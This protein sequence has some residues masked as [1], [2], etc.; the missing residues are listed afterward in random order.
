VNRLVLAELRKIFSTK[1]WWG[2][3][4]PVGCVAAVVGFAGAWF[5]DLALAA[6]DFEGERLPTLALTVPYCMQQTTVFAVV[7]GLIGGAGEFRHKTI[8]TTYLTAPSRGH[9]LAAKLI[10]YGALGVL[11]GAA[12]AVV[13]SLA[14]LVRSGGDAFPSPA[15]WLAITALGCVTTLAWTVLGVGLGTLIS[16]QVAVLIS[17]LVYKLLLEGVASII[18]QIEQVGL[19]EVARL[20]PGAASAALATDY[21]IGA[22]LRVAG[23]DGE[24]VR[25]ALEGLVGS[26]GQLPWWGGGLVFAAYTALFTVAGWLVSR[27]RDIT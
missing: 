17:V 24:E 16:N 25:F 3:L 4:I 10:G 23:E 15:E 20:L 8:T 5:G 12:T 27:Q 9:V 1:L 26:T 19:D 11:Y 14:A 21:G 7:L 13:C 18:L 2:L 6:E 22:F